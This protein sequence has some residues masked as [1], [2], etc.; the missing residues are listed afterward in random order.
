[1]KTS[2]RPWSSF[3]PNQIN[4]ERKTTKFRAFSSS[5]YQIKELFSFSIQIFPHNIENQLTC[6][7]SFCI[8]WFHLLHW[9]WWV[10]NEVLPGEICNKTN[11][12]FKVVWKK[13]K[14]KILV[15]IWLWF[16]C[17]FWRYRFLRSLPRTLAQYNYFKVYPWETKQQSFL[18]LNYLLM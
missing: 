14:V 10:Q 16:F 12:I 11:V 1:M 15:E 7:Y 3:C 6:N 17:F 4:R 18:F 5:I 8:K 2:K 9:N 13:K